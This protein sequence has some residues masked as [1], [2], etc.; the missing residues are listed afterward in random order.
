MGGGEGPGVGRARGGARLPRK[1]A[2]FFGEN[3]LNSG[4]FGQFQEKSGE[5][6]G[7]QWVFFCMALSMNSFSGNSWGISCG[8]SGKFGVRGP[9]LLFLGVFVSLVFF[10][11]RNSWKAH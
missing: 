1:R 4:K 11:P 8:S 7:I 5:L 6:S 10:L 2:P 3:T 9:V